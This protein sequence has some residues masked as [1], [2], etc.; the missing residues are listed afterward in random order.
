[1]QDVLRPLTLA[2]YTFL[3]GLI[4]SP[5]TSPTTLRYTTTCRAGRGC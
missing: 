5:S 1:M 3:I 2:D 4:E